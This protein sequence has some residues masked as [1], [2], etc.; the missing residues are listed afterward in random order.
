VHGATVVRSVG[1]L[2]GVS[3]ECPATTLLASERSDRSSHGL[4]YTAVTHMVRQA[5]DVLIKTYAHVLQDSMAAVAERIGSR[6]RR[7]ARP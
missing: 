5:A 4:R 1:D 7:S 2:T 3:P 6:R